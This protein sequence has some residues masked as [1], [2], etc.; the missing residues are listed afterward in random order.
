[1]YQ[2]Q[3]SFSWQAC[4]VS[5]PFVVKE[6]QRHANISL[7]HEEVGRANFLSTY[8][9]SGILGNLASLY[10]NVLGRNFIHVSL[11]ASGALFGLVGA[12]FTIKPEYDTLPTTIELLINKSF[13]DERSPFQ[14]TTK[15]Y[16]TT[17]G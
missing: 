14:S 4:H 2:I 15:Q 8:A 7:V 11:G 1:L 6:F 9:I 17:P 13:T 5:S 3:V 10:W 12:Y 16:P